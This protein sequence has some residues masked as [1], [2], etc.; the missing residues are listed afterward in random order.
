MAA[1]N[2]IGS[3]IFNLLLILGAT[4]TLRPLAQNATTSIDLGVMIGV[5]ALALLLMLTRQQLDRS[6]GA[7][8][9]GVYVVYMA[10]LFAS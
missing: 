8:L 4:A 10:W 1:G 9:V 5:T 6:E 7:L 3:N 2:L